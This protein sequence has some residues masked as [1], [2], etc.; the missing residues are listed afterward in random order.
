MI[1]TLSDEA[2]RILTIAAMEAGGLGSSRI[3]T[4]HLLL[5]LTLEDMRLINRFLGRGVAEKDF[6]HDIVGRV[7]V[8][9]RK[10]AVS[11]QGAFSDE[12][13]RVLSFAED[14]A[15]MMGCEE[16]GAEH[17]LLGILRESECLAAQ[18]L[19]DRGARL[20]TMRQELTTIPHRPV[21]PEQYAREL[22]TRIDEVLAL[23]EDGPALEETPGIVAEDRYAGY[24][25]GARRTIFYARYEATTLGSSTVETEH[26][27]LGVLREN[28]ALSRLY[29]PAGGTCETLRSEIKEERPKRKKAPMNNALPLSAEC[30]EALEL[31]KAESSALGSDRVGPA[32]L[33]LGLLRLENSEAAR[34]LRSHG[35]EIG[36]VRIKLQKGI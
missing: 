25:E 28:R 31:A 5:A 26:L 3:E 8:R 35:A 24:T 33:I 27:L 29:L 9:D 15:S 30:E 7:T 13:R 16:V 21:P 20:D 11:L 32:H 6:R 18:L 2:R 17:L 1:G 10:S 36:H 4:E 23:S 14:E 34:L 22:S 12:S 19:Y